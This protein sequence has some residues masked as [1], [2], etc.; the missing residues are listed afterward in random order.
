M[1]HRQCDG[2]KEYHS[3]RRMWDKR[4]LGDLR[5]DSTRTGDS[6]AL[7]MTGA[8]AARRQWACFASAPGTDVCRLGR[9]CCQALRKGACAE[10]HGDRQGTRAYACDNSVQIA[11]HPCLVQSSRARRAHGELRPPSQPAHPVF[12]Y[13]GRTTGQARRVRETRRRSPKMSHGM[14][15]EWCGARGAISNDTALQRCGRVSTSNGRGNDA[16][17]LLTLDRVPYA[18]QAR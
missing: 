14:P 15:W 9:K 10:A 3:R 5:G 4:R 11:E 16:V 18:K 12:T 8:L 7:C 2:W 1:A 17:S 13:V 6:D